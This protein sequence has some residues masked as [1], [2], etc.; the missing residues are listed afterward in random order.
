MEYT[1]ASIRFQENGGL[2]FVS[3]DDL[4]RYYFAQTLDEK[5]EKKLTLLMYS[6]R[7]G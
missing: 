7:F 4:K 3:A 5:S 6:R 1:R 2:A